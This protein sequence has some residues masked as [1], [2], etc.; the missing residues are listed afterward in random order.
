MSEAKM[1]RE[2]KPAREVDAEAEDFTDELT[3][4]AL[5]RHQ[6][7]VAGTWTAGPM[8]ASRGRIDRL[9]LPGGQAPV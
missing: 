9:E 1:Q 7:R 3:D 2:A 5:D 6:E 8:C 4:E